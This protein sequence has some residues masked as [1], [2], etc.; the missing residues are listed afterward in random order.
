MKCKILWKSSLCFLWGG[1][2]ASSWFSDHCCFWGS[3]WWMHRDCKAHFY[4][5]SFVASFCFFLFLLVFFVSPVSFGILNLS[6]KN[7]QKKEWGISEGNKIFGWQ[8][9]SKRSFRQHDISFATANFAVVTSAFYTMP[10]KCYIF[11]CLW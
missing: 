3:I 1:F 6:R 8:R 2:M 9:C 5:S 4:I 11:L 10:I 7:K